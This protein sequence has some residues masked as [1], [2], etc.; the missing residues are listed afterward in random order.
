MHKVRE[1]LR[2]RAAGL[3]EREVAASV[4]CARSTV[5]D[6]LKRA[7]AA[8]IGWPLPEGLDE[9]AAVEKLYRRAPTLTA[10]AFAEPD[11]AYIAQELKRK[12]VT[13]RQLWREYRARHPDGLKYTA[14]CVRYRQWCATTGAQATLAQEY[15]PGEYLFVDYGGDPAHVTDP[16]SGQ[17]RSVWLFTAAWGF[18]HWLYM[19][20]TETQ[21]TGDWLRAQVNALEAAGCVPQAIVPDNPKTVVKR[22]LRY[23]PELNR[24]YRDFAEHYGLAVLPA[25]VRRPRDKAKVE[26]AVQIGQRRVLA[27][28]RDAVFFSLADLNTAIGEIVA[29]LNAEPFQKRPGSRDELMSRYERPAAAA[30]PAR[31]YEYGAWHRA[32]VHRDHHV[33][34]ARGYYSVPYALIGRTVDVRRGA[35]LVEIFHRGALIAAHPLVERPYQ[36]RTVSEHR[37]PEHRAY[38]ALGFEQLLD[39]A[40]KI[41]PNTAAVL[42]KQA[43]GKRHIGETLRNAQGILRLAEDFTPTELEQAA[44]NALALAVYN[45]RALRDLLMQLRSLP[46]THTSASPHAEQAALSLPEEHENVRGPDYFH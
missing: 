2:L 5:Q 43:L 32:V 7:A 12:H 4:G 20:A 33:E 22:A 26:T 6:C 15:R 29:E 10:R 40:S 38:L 24:A 42:T 27:A 13:R 19:E 28:L 17:V 41:G 21:Q 45:Y 44:G 34:V 46:K 3:T 25:R 39:R 8:G 14:F 11:Y 37:P 31:R 1:I 18:S 30:L 36:R 9:A 16:L 23:D 35:Q